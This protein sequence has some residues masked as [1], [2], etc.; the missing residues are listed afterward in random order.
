[1][2]LINKP[3]DIRRI[4]G[5]AY[6]LLRLGIPNTPALWVVPANFFDESE[7]NEKLRQELIS[8]LNSVL[9]EGKRYAVRSSA[10]DEDSENA[11]FAGVHQSFLNVEKKDVF[12]YIL[13]VRDSAFSEEALEYRRLNGLERNKC[14]IA[15][16]IQEMVDA[17]FSGVAFTIDPATNNPDKIVISSTRGLGDKLVDGS[18]SGTTYVINGSDISVSG[19]DI[20]PPKVLE[21]VLKTVMLVAGK[22]TSF[23][24]IEFAVAENK[25]YFLQ[26]RPIAIYSGINPHERSLLIDNSN[27]IESYF[28]V[29]SPLT[30]SFAL[31]VYR[32]VYTA[33]LKCG[34]VRQR[35]LDSLA[36]SLCEML[37]Y[38]QGKIYYNM[39]SWY[40][41]NSIFPMKKS[42]SYMEAMMGVRSKTQNV[43]RV[44]LNA[45]DML[46]L[47]IA[48]VGSIAKIEKLSD[49]FEENFN[50]IVM[51]YYGKEINGT[52][53]QMYE[54]FNNIAREVVPEFTVPIINDCAVMIYFG[55]LKEKAKKYGIDENELN[56][57]ISNNGNVKS[58]GSAVDFADIIDSIHKDED[59]LRD[60]QTLSAVELKEKYENGTN[61]SEKLR[62][63]IF[64]F[65]AR[66]GDE[67]KLETI[68]MI[69]EPVL[70]YAQLKESLNIQPQNKGEDEIL[71]VPAK[72]RKSAEKTRKYIKNRER[73]R[74]KRTYVY[75]VIRNIFRACGRNYVAEGRID[76]AEDVFYLTKNEVFSGEGDFRALVELRKRMAEEYSAMPTYDRVVFYGD[77]HL[78]VEN[79][80]PAGGLC[81]IP[82][83]CGVVTGKVRIMDTPFDDF[84][85]G[86]IILT[87]RTDPGWISLFP[88]AAGIIVEH[89]SML[90][91]SFVVAREMKLPAVVGIRSATDIIPDGATVTLNGITGEI[92]VH[93][94]TVEEAGAGIE[95]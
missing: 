54:L 87:K 16:I 50:R 86:E 93:K 77:K 53:E 60:F 75:S 40:H 4:G 9:D 61:I 24:D 12:G 95:A 52:N 70:L 73:L 38:H 82:C 21:S 89:G 55:R 84:E 28:G 22:T 76:C 43:M 20:L 30:Y 59:T 88:K 64:D 45:L 74:L 17:D 90:S 18:V 8:E 29:T 67:L 19:E 71:T 65:G 62:K 63:Y 14:P 66:V 26:A 56:K 34:K 68:T 27:I 91:H 51:P 39:N 49:R 69:E 15:V 83:G 92:T 48:L 25:V 58:V 2:I 31:D 23:Q 32:D 72:I 35:I 36:P 85:K 46:K 42:G 7:V 44:K 13:K 94:E 41:V 10:V 47:G 33:T 57:Y 6:N 79:E 11:S 3:D 81:G 5:K 80:K 78:N 1:M 37:H